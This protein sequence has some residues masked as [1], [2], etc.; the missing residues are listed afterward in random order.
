[1][2]SHSQEHGHIALHSI[3]NTEVKINQ[4]ETQKALIN[5]KFQPKVANNLVCV[6]NYV[7]L[8]QHPSWPQINNHY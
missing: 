6:I 4:G 5:H 2:L 1:M 7:F 8:D 3:L